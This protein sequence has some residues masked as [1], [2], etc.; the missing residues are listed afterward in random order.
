[1]KILKLIKSNTKVLIGLAVGLA[2][3]TLGSVAVYAAIPDTSGV[4]HG[5]YTK[6]NGQLRIIDTATNSCSNNENAITWNQAGPQGLPGV[7][8]PQ[9]QQGAPGINGAAAYGRAVYDAN[10]DT[11]NLDSAHSK[12]VLQFHKSLQ[13]R[14]GAYCIQVSTEPNAVMTSPDTNQIGNYALKY[15]S[16][17]VGRPDFENDCD[18]YPGTNVAFNPNYWGEEGSFFVIY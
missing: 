16:G 10:T 17:W 4:F 2:V 15:D 11:Y 7:Q 3:G 9:G 5:C 6:N 13:S 12:G 14:W 1:M 8:G 18:A